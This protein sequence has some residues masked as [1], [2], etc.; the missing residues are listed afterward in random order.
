MPKR[1]SVTASRSA[2]ACVDL[3]MTMWQ[4]LQP[5]LGDC[6]TKHNVSQKLS[7]S[8]VALSPLVNRCGDL[9]TPM[10]RLICETLQI[11]YTKRIVSRKRNSFCVAR[12]PLVNRTQV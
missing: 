4:F 11:S 1:Y 6:S 9:S 8:Y 5:L 12:S 2:S 3:F 7:R 10:S